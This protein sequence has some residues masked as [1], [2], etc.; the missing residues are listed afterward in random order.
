MD[1]WLIGQWMQGMN[2]MLLKEVLI[3]ILINSAMFLYKKFIPQT[4]HFLLH[5]SL[6]SLHTWCSVFPQFDNKHNVS[7]QTQINST[8]S[9]HWSKL[10]TSSP[11][12]TQHAAQ[13]SLAF[14][15]F[16][17]MRGL[18]RG[19]SIQIHLNIKTLYAKT[20]TLFRTEQASNSSC[21]VEPVPHWDCLHY[22]V[23]SCIRLLWTAGLLEGLEWI[24]DIVKMQNSR[25]HR[26]GMT[27]ISCNICYWPS[28][29]QF[30]IRGFQSL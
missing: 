6:T 13:V 2:G 15:F 16:L 28:S 22:P 18:M 25:N 17:L 20:L 26:F 14:W 19:L 7:H 10:C 5:H 23:L 24:S 4:W 1:C 9:H 30:A 29:G 11:L 3:K 8:C 12:S 21:S 27:S